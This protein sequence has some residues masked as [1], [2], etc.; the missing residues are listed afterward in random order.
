MLLTGSSLLFQRLAA[1]REEFIN[2]DMKGFVIWDRADLSNSDSA[3]KSYLLSSIPEHWALLSKLK[4]HTLA[5]NGTLLGN[6]D[7]IDGFLVGPCVSGDGEGSQSCLLRL[8][9]MWLGWWQMVVLLERK[10]VAHG[11]QN[12]SGNII[13]WSWAG[14]GAS[15]HKRPS[16]VESL[17]S[18]EHGLLFP[19][20]LL[21]LV[22]VPN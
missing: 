9:H 2:E 21:C 22:A 5:S 4:S 15:Q 12:I 19:L 7:Q 18:K 14:F 3:I 1:H 6:E 17:S 16:K 10:R 8:C 11:A 13:W 20:H